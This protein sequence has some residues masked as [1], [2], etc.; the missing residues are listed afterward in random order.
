MVH[1]WFVPGMEAIGRAS[2]VA[3]KSNAKETT[4]PDIKWSLCPAFVCRQR[5]VKRAVLSRAA[6]LWPY[7]LD[8]SIEVSES[9]VCW[10]GGE[11]EGLPLARCPRAPPGGYLPVS[12]PSI[13]S[14]SVLPSC[15]YL[16]IHTHT[17][18]EQ[19]HIH[20]LW[21]RHPV[22]SCSTIYTMKCSKGSTLA[23]MLH[24]RCGLV[25]G[26]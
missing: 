18:M 17:C 20:I 15:D 25:K 11:L 1:T 21:Y 8:K 6:N 19:A 7:L 13:S 3:R 9:R 5:E 22:T 14:A 23:K 4:S 26:I 10:G 16:L 2:S 24:C 12:S